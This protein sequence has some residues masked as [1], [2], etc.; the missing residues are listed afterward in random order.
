MKSDMTLPSR[1]K[2]WPALARLAGDAAPV[3]ATYAFGT[4]IG[5]SGMHNGNFCLVSEHGRPGTLAA[6]YDC[7]P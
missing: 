5:K 3:Q 4:L 2:G 6:D 7:R 1:G